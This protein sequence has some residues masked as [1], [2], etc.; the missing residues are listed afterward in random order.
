VRAW[1]HLVALYARE[2]GNEC[3]VG[4][5]RR[6]T[7]NP[8]LPP[9][10]PLLNPPPPTPAR[11][12]L[13]VGVRQRCAVDEPRGTG[14]HVP[15]RRG[16]RLVLHKGRRGAPLKHLLVQL[17]Q[18]EGGLGGGRTGGGGGGSAQDVVRVVKPFRGEGELGLVLVV[19]FQSV[20]CASL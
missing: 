20:C 1:E 2:G 11:S 19:W 16:Q 17:Q 8:C 9:D 14:E 12:H 15:V 4:T 18:G 10:H 6:L 13:L 3:E 5:G 7:T